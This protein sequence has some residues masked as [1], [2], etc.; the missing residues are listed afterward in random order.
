[1][2]YNAHSFLLNF[3]MRFLSL[4]CLTILIIGVVSCTENRV[5]QCSRMNTVVNKIS[6][7]PVP[8]DPQQWTQLSAQLAAIGAELK[9]LSLQDPVLV[10]SQGKLVELS[11]E[12]S[13]SAQDLGKALQT[14]NAS[15]RNKAILSIEAFLKKEE[16]VI[17]EINQYCSS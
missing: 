2:G 5:S 17:N 4:F 10:S 11:A 13:R 15:Q 3:S 8:K 12:A 16:P 1:M 6:A 9:G 7:L 14:Q